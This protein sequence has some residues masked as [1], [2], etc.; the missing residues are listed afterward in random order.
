MENN[1]VV[2]PP[3]QEISEVKL[4][5]SGQQNKQPLKM[6][7]FLLLGFLLISAGAIFGY[8]YRD[9][10]LNLVGTNEVSQNNDQIIK[11]ESTDLSTS[12]ET[13]TNTKL[14]FTIQY[15]NSLNII[16][17]DADPKAENREYIRKCESGEI[18]GCGGSRSPDFRV[19]FQQGG[20]DTLFSVVV[21]QL[22]MVK[23]GLADLLKNTFSYGVRVADLN[24]IS[25]LSSKD[26][27]A[28]S[29]EN[30]LSTLTF[31]EPEKSL[32]CLWD[33]E[34]S[35]GFDPVDDKEYI[36]DNIE[37]LV[38]ISGYYVNPK[39]GVCEKAEYYSWLGQQDTHKPPF[40][41]QE[42]CRLTCSDK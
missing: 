21:Y 17:V 32:L 19:D 42:D 23:Y 22:P 38:L 25:N 30:L 10:H 12:L 28:L 24:N 5:S 31:I 7:M 18:D 26:K 6:I 11:V 3:V 40:E 37:G 4:G 33:T 13:Y 29:K 16:P 8:F 1:Q 27:L 2:V 9:S 35:L 41:T 34:I 36:D 14:G 15:P 39:S 20:E